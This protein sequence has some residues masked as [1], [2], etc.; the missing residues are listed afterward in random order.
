MVYLITWRHLTK[1]FLFP[2]V[3]VSLSIYIFHAFQL[4]SKTRRDASTLFSNLERGDNRREKQE[5]TRRPITNAN[6]RAW[7]VSWVKLKTIKQQLGVTIQDN[8]ERRRQQDQHLFSEQ[9]LLMPPF[10]SFTQ[11]TKSTSWLNSS[12]TSG[13][14][15]RINRPC[16]KNKVDQDMFIKETWLV[17]LFSRKTHVLIGYRGCRYT[18]PVDV[19]STLCQATDWGKCLNCNRLLNAVLSAHMFANYIQILAVFNS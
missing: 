13:F 2:T 12:W 8:D 14:T 4:Y 16:T 7:K 11:T 19:V 1:R 10:F 3:I 9:F 17:E 15:C 5:R 18:I 6:V